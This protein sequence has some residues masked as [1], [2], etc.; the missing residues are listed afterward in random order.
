MFFLWKK[1]VSCHFVFHYLRADFDRFRF[2]ICFYESLF[3]IFELVHILLK[4]D[5]RLTWRNSD[6]MKIFTLRTTKKT[7][8]TTWARVA[9]SQKIALCIKNYPLFYKNL[10]LRVYTSAQII[11]YEIDCAIFYKKLHELFCQFIS[12]KN[13]V[14][15]GKF[16]DN[17]WISCQVMKL[18]KKSFTIS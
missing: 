12:W 9:R 17:C 13:W 15:S 6:W 4:R 11:L 7:I 10:Q 18:M 5:F 14:N 8:S 3:T 2:K 1:H 16:M